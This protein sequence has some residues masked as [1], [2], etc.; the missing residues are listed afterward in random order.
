[1]T[2]KKLSLLD[3]AKSVKQLR[4]NGISITPEHIELALA[5]VKDEVSLTQVSAALKCKSITMAYCNIAF[6]LKEYIKKSK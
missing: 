4:K 6:A 2:T 1:M 5:W 3:T